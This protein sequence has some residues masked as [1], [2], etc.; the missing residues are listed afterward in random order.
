M[1]TAVAPLDETNVPPLRSRPEGGEAAY[2]IADVAEFAQ[3]TLSNDLCLWTTNE[4]S[5]KF[6]NAKNKT[7]PRT[8]VVIIFRIPSKSVLLGYALVSSNVS[9]R[10]KFGK[11]AAREAPSTWGDSLVR[12]S[13]IRVCK[14]TMAE[15]PGDLCGSIEKLDADEEI[16]QVTGIALCN[17]VDD[18]ARKFLP[19]DSMRGGGDQMPPPRR[20]RGGGRGF[21]Y[22][23]P[24]GSNDYGPPSHHHYH[25]HHHHSQPHHHHHHS[26][27]YGGYGGYPPPPPES[28]YGGGYG[29][30]SGGYYAPPPHH[31]HHHQHSHHHHHGGYPQ[32]DLA[33]FNDY[34][35]YVRYAQQR[36]GGGY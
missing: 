7:E 6:L 31:H 17:A 23:A 24:R 18:A 27:G 32:P 20:G 22:D 4:K 19:L 16:D 25:H 5:R 3:A 13:W 21:G 30:P 33:Q 26:G 9:E 14:S 34:E 1:P 12:I 8:P 28:G 29:Y 15:L 10:S 36:G 11:H 35:A 2:M